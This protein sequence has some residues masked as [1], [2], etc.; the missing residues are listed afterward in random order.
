MNTKLLFGG[1]IGAVV[2]FLLGWL[3]YGILLAD[4]MAQYTNPA[5]ARPMEEMNMGMMILGNL[6]WGLTLSYILSNWSGA[7][8]MTSGAT[9]GAVIGCLYAL[10][11]GFMMYSTTTMVN[12]ITP[13]I[14]DAVI[15]AVM[16]GAAGAAIGWWFARK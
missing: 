14:L 3:L 1:I 2:L 8:N 5:C 10:A 15:S 9:A 12:S 11:Y 6:F 4:T 13:V 16:Y 7:V